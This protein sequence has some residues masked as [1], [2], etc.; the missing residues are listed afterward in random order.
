VHYYDPHMPWTSA[1]D[2]VRARFVDPDYRGKAGGDRAGIGFLT[3]QTLLGTLAE[4]DRTHA[5]NL[6][7]SEVA[8]ADRQ[9][10][11][12]LRGLGAR[13]LL[14]DSLVVVFSD[15][16]EMFDEEPARPFRHGPDVDLP[17]IHVPLLVRGTGRFAVPGGRVV[18]T[19]VRTLDIGSTVL[20]AV[21]D[22]IPLGGGRDLSALWSDRPPDTWPLSFAEAT[23]P[24][25]RLRSDT[26]PN[27]DLERA[28][29]SQDHIATRAPWLGLP[30]QAVALDAPGA[31]VERVPAELVGA[32]D[33][34][35]ARMPGARQ[36]AYDDETRSA[37]EALGYLDD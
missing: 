6:Y 9:L 2:H 24:L 28:V 19:T 7:L 34:F 31:V 17:I 25:D 16:G 12:L 8:W 22:D 30:D 26:W 33:A 13:N 15:H 5:R 11:L 27:A 29:V 20:A 35:D 1:P 14:Q 21:G 37:L 4:A 10:G 3:D 32:L 23:K 18:D 36:E